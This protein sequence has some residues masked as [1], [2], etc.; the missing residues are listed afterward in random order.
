[1]RGRL[2]T[3]Y[4]LSLTLVNLLQIPKLEFVKLWVDYPYKMFTLILETP[5]CNLA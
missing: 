5:T 2:S 1:M 3:F 4:Q